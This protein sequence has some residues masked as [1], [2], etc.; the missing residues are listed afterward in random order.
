MSHL[1]VHRCRL[2]GRGLRGRQ[3]PVSTRVTDSK[4]SVGPEGP[5]HFRREFL[6]PLDLRPVQG[7]ISPVTPAPFPFRVSVSQV[8][9]GVPSHSWAARLQ[10]CFGVG[11]PKQVPKSRLP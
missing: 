8:C 10:A 1:E 6:L 5:Q 4:E 7:I 9:T 2:E 11:L 3:E